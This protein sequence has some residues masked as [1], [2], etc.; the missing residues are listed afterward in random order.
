MK[1]FILLRG[2]EGSGKSTFAQQQINAFLHDF[3]NAQIVLIDN[4]L[5]LTDE[6][7]IYH[8]DF[9]RFLLAHRENQAR[10]KQAFLS[11]VHQSCPILILNANPNQKAKT[12]Y[13]MLEMAQEF[14]FQIEIYRL[15]GFFQNIH[16]VSDE[17]VQRSYARLNANPVSGE[18]HLDADFQPI[19]E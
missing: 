5:A 4:D 9:E 8:F 14:D 16:G 13:A 1:K 15:H 10:Q 2:H 11:S 7:G 6:N 18:I 3:P 19:I 12:C 17:D